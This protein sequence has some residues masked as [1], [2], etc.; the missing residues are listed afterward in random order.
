M[1][2][3]ISAAMASVG[4]ADKW[5]RTFI[6]R[7]CSASISYMIIRNARDHRPLVDGAAKKGKSALC[8]PPESSLPRYRQDAVIDAIG[9]Y[10]SLGQIESSRIG[11]ASRAG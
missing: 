9:P 2:I 11:R 3:N 10:R 1:L 8:V 7:L 4:I 6:H 5:R